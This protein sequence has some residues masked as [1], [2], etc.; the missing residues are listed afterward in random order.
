MISGE[1][2][3]ADGGVLSHE[4]DESCLRKCAAS[5]LSACPE[6]K[7]K[8]KQTHRAFSLR[9]PSPRH[10]QNLRRIPS[11]HTNLQAAA[12]VAGSSIFVH[13]NDVPAS[14]QSKFPHWANPKIDLDTKV[15]GKGRSLNLDPF[16][17]EEEVVNPSISIPP[18]TRTK[19][20]SVDLDQFLGEGPGR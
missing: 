3:C 17:R 14:F 18:C 6:E 16:L 13:R 9:H 20:Q 4:L 12:P 1:L 19:C 7:E 10:T 11:F 8:I 15:G 5:D 2:C